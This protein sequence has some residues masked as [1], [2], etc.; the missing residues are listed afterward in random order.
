MFLV[1][2]L[3]QHTEI[4]GLLIRVANSSADIPASFGCSISSVIATRSGLS[5]LIDSATRWR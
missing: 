5:D 1:A 2:D 3:F 4:G